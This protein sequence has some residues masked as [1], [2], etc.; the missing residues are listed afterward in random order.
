M[1]L[2]LIKT[3]ELLKEIIDRGGDQLLDPEPQYD[4]ILSFLTRDEIET[5]MDECGMS[6]T[7]VK[8]RVKNVRR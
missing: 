6:L 3:E 4:S 8:E 2:N 5:L 7:I 1:K